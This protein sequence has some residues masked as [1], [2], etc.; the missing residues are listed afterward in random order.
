MEKNVQKKKQKMSNISLLHYYKLVFRSLLFLA[1][2]GM[3]IFA[4]VK[5]EVFSTVFNFQTNDLTDLFVNFNPLSALLILI[6][7]IEMV[8][9]T[10]RFFPSRFES[11]GCQKQFK[12]NYIPNEQATA[13]AKYRE[14]MRGVILTAVLW[15][16]L[17]GTFGVFYFFFPKDFDQG[18]LLLI[19]LAF[20]IC[21]M[22][23]ILFFCPFHTWFMKNKCC[24]SCRIYN[25]D[26]FMMFSPLIFIPS[27]Y[28][29]TL[30]AASL[31]LLIRWEVTAALHPERFLER[32]NQALKCANCPEKLCHHKR[33][34][35]HYLK[36]YHALAKTVINETITTIKDKE[37]YDKD[38]MEVDEHGNFAAENT[39]A[40]TK[41]RVDT[42]VETTAGIGSDNP[43]E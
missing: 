40:E 8:E 1:A 3:Y 19:S 14:S 36:K 22:I 28:T 26:Y 2:V 18:V 34:L 42:P 38:V 27:W 35:R 43:T 4:R 29:W 10:L 17:I 23:C 20:S 11:M 9:M 32:T 5:P 37:S 33:Q 30:V 7:I 39:A 12:R 41:E 21:D 13:P 24:G 6:W 16:L 31:M 25:W 15:C